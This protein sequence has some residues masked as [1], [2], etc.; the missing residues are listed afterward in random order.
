MD[1]V[2]AVLRF[3]NLPEKDYWE[4]MDGQTCPMLPNG[5]LAVYW[6][7]LHRYV[8]WKEKGIVPVWD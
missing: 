6:Y 7:D 1:E 8:T 3:F 2:K 4:W 5:K